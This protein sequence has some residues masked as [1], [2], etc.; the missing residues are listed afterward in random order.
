ML[1]S[2]L[3]S[4]ISP[5][6]WAQDRNDTSYLPLAVGN[7]WTYYRLQDHPDGSID[8][9]IYDP[10]RI[11]E[12]FDLEGKTYYLYPLRDFFGID[13]LRTDE[14]GR[15]FGRHEGV[16]VMLFDF[17]LPDSATYV[18]EGSRHPASPY[19]V[20]VRRGVTVDIL[21]GRFLNS[22]TFIFDIPEAVD[23]ENRFTFYP[24]VGLIRS[25]GGM[26][27]FILLYEARIG[28]QIVTATE[29]AVV[30]GNSSFET[31]FP[32]PF[33]ETTTLPFTPEHSGHATLKI[34]DVLGREVATLLDGF[35]AAH[36]QQAIWNSHEQ[37]AGLYIAQLQ[38]GGV[39][40]SRMLVRTR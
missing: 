12:S 40:T 7:E 10:L 35:V 38:M 22:I 9:L 16:D 29:E 8:T 27:E 30:P 21:G 4:I 28:G 23:D 24:G 36:P 39:V 13:T 31:A 5:L 17:T 26:G 15:V 25:V 2:L 3:F 14:T 34:Y 18:Y 19:I 32:N 37:P 1:G 6:A 33:R 11:T 20:T